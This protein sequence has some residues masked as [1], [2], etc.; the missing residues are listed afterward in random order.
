VCAGDGL[1]RSEIVDLLA[2]LVEK[3]LVAP[4]DVTPQHRYRLLETVRLYAQ[5]RLVEIGE[6]TALAERQAQWALAVAEGKRDLPELDHETANLLAALDTLLAR[7][8]ENALRLC[9]ALWTFWLRRIDLAEAERRFEAALAAAP[10]RTALRAEALLAAAALEVRGGVLAPALAHAQESRE[11]AVEIGDLEA[12]WR[13]LHF[14]GGFAISYD[15]ADA[16]PWLEQGLALARRERFAAAEAVGIYF[17]GAARWFAGDPKGAEERVAES[18]E[19]F[20]ALGDPSERIPSPANIAEMRLPPIDGGQGSRIVL[21]DSLQPFVEVSSD[22]ALSYALANQAGIARLRGDLDR[23]RALLDESVE[24]FRVAGDERGQ[25]D[26]LVR[27]A[28]LRLAEGALPEAR[29][30]LER[31]LSFRRAQNDR[32]GVGLVLSGLAMIDTEAG[33]H[34]SAER[35]LEEAR[36]LFRRAGDRWGLVI[37]LFR[38]ADLEMERGRIETAEAALEEAQAVLGHTEMSR[39][40][41]HTLAGLAE[42]AVLRG[43]DERARELLSQARERYAQR[44]DTLG[45]AAVDKR[46]R[47]MQS[48]R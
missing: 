19:A 23:A 40:I 8:P 11:V 4:V 17:L 18:I 16:M 43:D 25:I 35:R 12:E 34:E 20:R 36:G 37:A 2:R 30:C 31:A 24:R 9:V 21:E 22:A 3:S 46:L 44:Q 32:R 27:R 14:L 15:M 5:D 39:W 42:V 28:Y 38:T 26:V 7:D 1:E 6:E 41:A 29:D 48:R 47:S 13:A 45:V 10:E 33:D